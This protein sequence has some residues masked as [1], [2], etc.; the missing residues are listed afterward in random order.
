MTSLFSRQPSCFQENSTTEQ[1]D[2]ALAHFLEELKGCR[3]CAHKLPLGPRPVVRLSP[4]A[5][6]LIAGQAPGTRVHNTGI[7]FNDASG[8]RLRS[9]LAMSPDVF[10]DTERIAIVPMA[11]CYPGVL[12]K[13][14]DRPP[15]PECAAL[16][17]E[18]ILSFLPNLRLTLLVGSYAQN[19]ALGKGKVFERVLDF[20]SYLPRDFPL[21]HPSWRTEAWERKTPQ[22]QEDVIPALREAVKSALED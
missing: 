16:W 17:R 18:R 13:G 15:P 22:F 9:W 1:Q 4:R 11:L 21:P 14:G 5:R 12:P 20:R 3:A 6:L 8:E 19:Y 7:P 2:E 10:Y